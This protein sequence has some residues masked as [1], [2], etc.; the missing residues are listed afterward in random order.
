MVWSWRSRIW[1]VRRGRKVRDEVI[2]ELSP[3]ATSVATQA[4]TS[5]IDPYVVR[6]QGCANDLGVSLSKSRTV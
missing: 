6:A 2:M 3:L 1:M 5:T 4:P